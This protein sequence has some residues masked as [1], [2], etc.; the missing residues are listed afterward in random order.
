MNTITSLKTDSINT[1][2]TAAYRT[3]RIACNMSVAEAASKLG[4]SP[5]TLYAYERGEAQP[6]AVVLRNMAIIYHTSADD[7]LGLGTSP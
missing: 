7:L 5:N 1:A 6:T 2:E 3:A 4:V